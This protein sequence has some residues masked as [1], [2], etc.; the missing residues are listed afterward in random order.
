M[1]RSVPGVP[2]SARYVQGEPHRP[3]TEFNNLG[4]V[5][6]PPTAI[7]P[8]SAAGQGTGQDKNPVLLASAYVFP[9]IALC[10]AT[11]RTPPGTRTVIC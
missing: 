9:L 3:Q 5:G 2:F 1:T 7:R 11:F 4:A 6:S 10:W 8:E